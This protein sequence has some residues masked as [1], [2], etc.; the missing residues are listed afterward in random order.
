M[1]DPHRLF[2]CIDRRDWAAFGDFLADDV[3]FR[4]G[5]QPAVHGK[6]A[7][8]AAAAAALAPFSRVEHRFERQWADPSDTVV[9]GEVSYTLP[10]GR[11]IRLDF[12][13]RLRFREGSIGEYL[14]FI[15]AAPVFA[16]LQETP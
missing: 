11:V 15:D 3:V 2:A 12:L 13:N 4:Y 6:A 9:A 8:L 10:S 7:V 16:A 5:S 1:F 14:I